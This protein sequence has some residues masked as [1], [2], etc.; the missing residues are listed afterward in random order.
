M[1]YDLSIQ[2]TEA[3][4][5]Q[6]YGTYVIR[7]IGRID[8]TKGP[9]DL[10]QSWRVRYHPVKWFGGQTVRNATKTAW[11][12]FL[13]LIEDNRAWQPQGTEYGQ[14]CAYAG[15]KPREILPIAVKAARVE[16]W[17]A[18]SVVFLVDFEVGIE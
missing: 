14:K 10:Y 13:P 6:Y 5:D 17:V 8:I 7:R 3:V 12:L 1:N 16:K 2:P 9:T 11:D 18:E 15:V 4:K